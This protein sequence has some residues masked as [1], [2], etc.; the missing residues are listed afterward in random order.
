MVAAVDQ[1]P[2]VQNRAI[3]EY[4]DRLAAVIQDIQKAGIDAETRERVLADLAGTGTC[5]GLLGVEA[6][7]RGR[8]PPDH[9]AAR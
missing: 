5:R 2:E 4:R 7:L 6:G 1:A 9:G 3:R 8:S